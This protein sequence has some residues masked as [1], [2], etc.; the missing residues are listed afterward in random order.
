MAGCIAHAQNCRT[1]SFTFLF[2]YKVITSEAAA[3]MVYAGHRYT[4]LP[5]SKKLFSNFKAF[6]YHKS[7]QKFFDMLSAGQHFAW[8]VK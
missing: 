7:L 6:V 1:S 4:L 3:V 2:R 8:I 5:M